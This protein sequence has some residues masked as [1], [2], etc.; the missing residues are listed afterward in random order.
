M[1][2]FVNQP[3]KMVAQGL[4]GSLRP[5][6]PGRCG[7]VSSAHHHG[8]DGYHWSW[9]GY[10]SDRCG[11]GHIWWNSCCLGFQRERKNGVLFIYIKKKDLID[12]KFL[13]FLDSISYCILILK[14]SNLP[15]RGSYLPWIL[16]HLLFY[17]ASSDVLCVKAT[18][19]E[20]HSKRLG[21]S[22]DTRLNWAASSNKCT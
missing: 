7:V 20:I 4:P 1:V 18:T 2:V 14:C 15:M 8:S 11:E 13:F 16:S 9:G 21:V 19:N 22:K 12:W 10:S 3:I 5:S 17:H 6:P